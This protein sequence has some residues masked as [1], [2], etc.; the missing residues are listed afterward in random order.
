MAE[1]VDVWVGD[2]LRRARLDRNCSQSQL[3]LALGISFQQIQKYERGANR[4]SASRL[5]AAC[6]FLEIEVA[7]VFPPMLPRSASGVS[8]KPNARVRRDLDYLV[9]G[10]TPANRRILTDVA[11]ALAG[12]QVAPL[13]EEAA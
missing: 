3:A 4:I 10:L 2:A 12:Q 5:F 6:A 8:G 1:D 7:D 13:S 11:K 9:E